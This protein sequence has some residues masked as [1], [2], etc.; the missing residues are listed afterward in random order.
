MATPLMIFANGYPRPYT[1]DRAEIASATAK[2]PTWFPASVDFQQ[3]ATKSGDAS[4][5][6]TLDEMLKAIE[7]KP[8][9]SISLLGLV[10]HAAGGTGGNPRTFGLSGQITVNPANVI[11]TAKGFVNAD[12]LAASQTRITS[13]RNRFTSDAHIVFYACNTGLDATLLDAISNA[14]GVCADGFS[15]EVLWCF[16]WATPSMV[17]N[18]RGRVFYDK[19]GM[20]A[21]GLVDCDGFSADATSLTPDLTSCVGVKGKSTKP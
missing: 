10:G 5:A 16:K 1:S 13:L 7:A 11:L 14:F 15:D 20:Y 12:T 17:I 3:T 19:N 9:A 6:T 21:A 4:G 8:A 2:P 18:S